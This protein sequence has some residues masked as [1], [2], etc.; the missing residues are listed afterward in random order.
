MVHSSCNHQN[1]SNLYFF[2]L[3]FDSSWSVSHIPKNEFLDDDEIDREIEI[4]KNFL[5][6]LKSISN[7][8]LTYKKDIQNE[9]LSSID[10][11][12]IEQKNYIKMRRYNS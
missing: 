3:I 5:K 4:L 10:E 7:T 12:I 6:S 11:L 1:K 2:F 9:S 8:E